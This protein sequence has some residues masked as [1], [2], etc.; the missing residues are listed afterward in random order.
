M[1]PNI[2]VCIYASIIYNLII[3]NI[4]SQSSVIPLHLP[5]LSLETLS[6][7]QMEGLW[8]VVGRELGLF[9]NKGHRGMKLGHRHWHHQLLSFIFISQSNISKVFQKVFN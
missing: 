4:Y 7:Q 5:G 6:I 2:Y 9:R 3:K 8:G 1:N